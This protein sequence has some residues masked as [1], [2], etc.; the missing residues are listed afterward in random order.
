MLQ[1]ILEIKPL[2]RVGISAAIAALAAMLFYRENIAPTLL[3]VFGWCVFATVFLTLEW[4]IIAKRPTA[5]IRE[6]AAKDDGG[7]I[8]V[9]VIIGISALATLIAVLALS[10]EEHQAE[11]KAWYFL[12][13]IVYAMI[14][15]WGIIHTHFTFHYAHKYYAPNDKGDF[16]RGLIFPADEKDPDYLDFAYYS[17][18]MGTTFQVSDISTG[19]KSMRR[20]TMLHGLLAF[21]LNTFV[22]ALTINLVAGIWPSS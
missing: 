5:R 10:L 8:T 11:E 12:P 3:F 4:L 1:K 7:R 20:L 19:S 22:V 6:I 14:S 15:S 17:L 16:E 13:M 21:F 9:V 18:C 2:R